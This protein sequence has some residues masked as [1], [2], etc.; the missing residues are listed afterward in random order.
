[1]NGS[2]VL[3]DWIR[4]AGI[5]A[6]ALLTLGVAEAEENG[7]RFRDWALRCPQPGACVLEQRVFVEG[8]DE[9]PLVHVAF[10][11]AGEPPRL[12]ASVR[13]PLGVLL[14]PGIELSVDGGEPLTFAFHHCRPEGC[15]ALF[16]LD[17]AMRRGFERGR[18]A[19]VRYYLAD[20]RSLGL[21]LSLLGITAGLQALGAETPT[22]SR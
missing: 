9:T 20:G 3:R 22:L 14:R 2:A 12:L 15:L 19:Q 7:R 13:V 11:T 21:P 1:M 16:A 4:E 8:N 10:Q 6:L 17:D 18:A 5:L